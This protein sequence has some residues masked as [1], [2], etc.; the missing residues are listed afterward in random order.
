MNSTRASAE[1]MRMQSGGCAK[2]TRRAAV[3][4]RAVRWRAV[5]L[6][7]RQC[8]RHGRHDAVPGDRAQAASA[9]ITIG[10][11]GMTLKDTGSWSRPSGVPGLTFADEAATANALVP[12][13]RQQGADAIVL[14]IHQGGNHQ[15]Y[16]RRPR[17]RRPD[18][19]DPADPRQAR[20]GDHARSSPATPTR[21]MCA[22]CDGRRRGRL[23]TSAGKY[24]YF[25]HRHPAE[26]RPRAPT[27]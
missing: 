22:S 8:L 7:R 1:L 10:F 26:L 17:L 13:S 11:I 3:R 18:G 15:G 24:G 19:D 23:L 6:P 4:G 25:C 9:P 27:G 21:P 5:P 2:F 12:R 20:P 14:L 16:S